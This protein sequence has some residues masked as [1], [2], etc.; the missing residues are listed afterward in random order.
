MI[1]KQTDNIYKPLVITGYILYGLLVISTLTSAT[2]PFGFM[3]FNP[4]II[5]MNAAT[6]MIALTLGSVLPMLL[7]YLAGD[8]AVRT[9]SRWAH[10]FNGVLFGLL[11]YWL[12]IS[13]AFFIN[14][15]YDTWPQN[16][17]M[18]VRALLPSAIIA[19]VCGLLAIMHVR[20]KLAKYDVLSYRPFSVLI[21][22]FAG[23]I[24]GTS[25]LQVVFSGSSE[26]FVY[27]TTGIILFTGFVAYVSAS[28]ARLD[29]W[30]KVSWAAIS[31]SVISVASFVFAQLTNSIF[32]Y[33]APHPTYD[34]YIVTTII[35]SLATIGLWC[36]YW[37][38][39]SKA[40]AA[41]RK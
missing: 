29:V 27:L 13:G 39:Q 17:T 22:A 14:L 35:S 7:G 5:K 23:L 3:L 36:V 30:W 18:I 38:F 26:L 15:P 25:S 1:K 19:T 16:V 31:I 32:Q 24:L 2:I 20:S 8:H 10:H 40:L 21:T 33:V 4:D 28:K 9:K 34:Y 37:H 12:M 6:A 41:T 11:A